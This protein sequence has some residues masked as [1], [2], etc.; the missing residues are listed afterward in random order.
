MGPYIDQDG[1]FVI[2]ENGTKLFLKRNGTIYVETKDEALKQ[3]L[4]KWWYDNL[5]RLRYD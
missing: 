2:E 3:E 4:S 5:G 1:N